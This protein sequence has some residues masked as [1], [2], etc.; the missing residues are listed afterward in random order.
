MDKDALMYNSAKKL[1][2]AIKKKPFQKGLLRSLKQKEK[3]AIKTINSVE[4]LLQEISDP[5]ETPFNKT[6]KYRE[7]KNMADLKTTRDREERKNNE[8]QILELFTGK[9]RCSSQFID[10]NMLKDERILLIL[11]GNKRSFGGLDESP[12]LPDCPNTVYRK[13]VLSTDLAR[14]KLDNIL[15][16]N[17]YKQ[18]LL[19][20]ESSLISN[21]TLK[22]TSTRL[23]S[24]RMDA[25][26]ESPNKKE[27][28]QN[29][30]IQS[31]KKALDPRQ[32]RYQMSSLIRSTK[33]N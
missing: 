10:P 21:F 4:S 29:F 25:H 12:R 30:K 33:K 23:A 9:S 22:N 5:K 31:G 6:R 24:S 16:N 27:Y 3:N 11:R 32:I 7:L 28:L 18:T 1:D 20:K 17:T 14:K 13:D 8:K 2:F 26:S 19:C 15:Y